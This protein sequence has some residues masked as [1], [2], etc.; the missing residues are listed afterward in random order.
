MADPVQLV[1][2]L[3]ESEL[4]ARGTEGVAA[5]LRDVIFAM[6]AAPEIFAPE[7]WA[8]SGSSLA[9]VAARNLRSYVARHVPAGP[10]REAALNCIDVLS[11]E[12][13]RND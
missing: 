10:D 12:A 9:H 3:L 11:G 7:G 5:L 6:R 13:V 4:N 2:E 8:I 1:R